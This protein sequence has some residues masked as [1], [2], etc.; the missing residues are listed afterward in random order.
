MKRSHL[1]ASA[2][3]I[4]GLYFLWCAYKPDEWHFLDNV[5]LVIHEAGHIVFMPFGEF[6]MIAGGSLFQVI[7]PLVFC[8]YF[9]WRG[10]YYAGCLTAFWP[11]ESILNVSVYA[12]D[13]VEMQL[14]LLGGQ[15][16]IHDWNY[17]LDRL[18]MLGSTAT[19][20][21][22]IRFAGALTIIAALVGAI[23]FALADADE[24]ASAEND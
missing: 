7:V 10:Q 15:D 24:R 22:L 11:G 8:G 16:S 13:A 6:V 12:R 23:Y 20:A 14:P 18:G 2:A 9:F 19:I 3:L 1:K 5:N 4:V 17:M 21:G